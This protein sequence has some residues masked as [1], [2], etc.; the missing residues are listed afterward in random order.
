MAFGYTKNYPKSWD[1]GSHIQ[2]IPG[3]KAQ[4]DWH[5]DRSPNHSIDR[6]ISAVLRRLSQVLTPSG[7]YASQPRSPG[8]DIESSK[9]TVKE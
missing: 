8:A 7:G 9:V 3:R 5:K 2:L 4:G 1:S 6:Y